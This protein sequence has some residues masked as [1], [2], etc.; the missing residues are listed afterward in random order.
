MNLKSRVARFEKLL[1]R[2]LP[3]GASHLRQEERPTCYFDLSELSLETRKQML[4]EV[5][6]LKSADR[7]TSTPHRFRL[8]QLSVETRQKMLGDII[9]SREKANIKEPIGA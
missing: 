9:A 4:A 6:R 3:R 1:S 8:E 5:K 7:P 2:P